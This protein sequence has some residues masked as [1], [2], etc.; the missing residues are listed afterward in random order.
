MHNVT[1]GTRTF[2]TSPK[3][4]KHHYT[5]GSYINFYYKTFHILLYDT[6]NMLTCVVVITFTY[7]YM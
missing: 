2:S 1:E 5:F 7:M 4:K 3:A 6:V